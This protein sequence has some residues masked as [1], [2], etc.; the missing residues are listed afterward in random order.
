MSNSMDAIHPGAYRE[1]LY[2]V[3]AWSPTTYLWRPQ[4]SR[5]YDRLALS[6]AS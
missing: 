4:A 3:L 5:H 6:S 1:H 2:L